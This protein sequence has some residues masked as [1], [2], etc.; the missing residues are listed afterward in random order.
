M[1]LAMLFFLA[2]AIIAATIPVDQTYWAQLFVGLIVAPWGMDMSFPAAT[3]ILSESVPREHQGIAASL[4]STV[5][6][7]SISIGL[8]IGGTVLVNVNDGGKDVLAGY[9]GAW[10]AGIGLSAVGVV[11]SLIAMGREVWSKKARSSGREGH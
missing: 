8:G 7:Y 5:V 4:I 1:T 6:N 3:I 10:Y 9:R 2:A 11:V